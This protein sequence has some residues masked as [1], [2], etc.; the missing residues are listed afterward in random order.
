MIR[1]TRTAA[2]LL[3]VLVLLPACHRPG[4]PRPPAADPAP[5]IE[6]NQRSGTVDVVGLPGDVLARLDARALTRD[7]WNAV[8]R[9]TVTGQALPA[10]ERPAML[11]S[12]AVTDGTLR[13]TPQFPLDPGQHYDVVFDPSRLGPA[14][15]NPPAPWRQ[16][17]LASSIGIPA[18]DAHPTTHVVG[19]FPSAPEVPE[20]HLRMYVTFSAP[21]SL[22]AGSPYISLLDDRGQPVADPFL[23]LDVDLWNADRTR[24][25]VFFDPGRQKSGIL[26]NEEMGRSLTVGRKYTLVVD[27]AWRDG[28]GQ[29]LV[30]S[31]RREFRVGPAEERAIDP[32]AWR[33]DAPPAGTR[34]SLVVSFPRPLDYGLLH[35]ALAVSNGRGEIVP[36]G[37]RLDAGETR[38]LFTPGAAWQ[39]GEYRLLAA[40]VLEDVSG[41]RI[42]RPFE[43]DSHDAT[44]G[45]QTATSAALPF[46]IIPVAL[47]SQGR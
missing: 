24:Y 25:T 42:G 5:R 40:S 13:F 9:V 28:G 12:Y 22:A 2:A 18:P 37:I 44:G 1:L 32:A 20:N 30:T 8:L 15:E 6:L 38:W 23:P 45:D 47:H 29:P 41:N 10:G 17:P 14:N 16:H 26:P 36:G 3:A 33:I 11:G 31:F 21:M 7:E 35:S 46:R 27:Q 4:G 19:V 34:Q 43:V 39:S